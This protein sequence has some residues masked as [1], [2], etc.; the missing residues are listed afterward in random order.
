MSNSIT[1]YRKTLDNCIGMLCFQYR[2]YVRCADKDFSRSSKFTFETIIR[3]I[4]EF[5]AKSLQNEIN[6]HFYFN[7][8][9]IGTKSAFIQQRA[10]IKPHAFRQLFDMFLSSISMDKTFYGYRLVACDGTQINL[11]RNPKDLET[12]IISNPEGKSHNGMHM[13]ALFDLGKRVYIDYM[14]DS[15][16]H[17]HEL[18]NMISM[19]SKLPNPENTIMICDRGFGFYNSIAHL[20]ELGMRFLI[21]L[22]DIHSNGFIGKYGLP[23]TEFDM[24]IQKTLVCSNRKEYKDNPDYH[25]LQKFA[26]DYFDT[27]PEFPI[28]FRL[29]RFEIS[30][31]HFE[32]LATNL[33]RDTFPPSLLKE[34]Y[35]MR[36]GI[37]TYF[38]NLKYS[39]G[40]MYFHSLKHDSVIQ[41][42]HASMLML[43]FCSLVVSETPIAQK[44]DCKWEYHVNF[45][46][47]VAVCRVILRAKRFVPSEFYAVLFALNPCPTRPNR[48][49]K[50]NLHDTMPA[51]S[52]LY[53]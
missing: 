35:H 21:R 51:M 14:L 37:E 29:V 36:W 38:R 44:P 18:K 17:F 22:K 5:Q 27:A 41:E 4:L 26:F 3:I 16:C 11:P 45:A 53:R 40:M 46:A 13:T 34:L 25:I 23:D 19:A 12:T 39:L 1:G 2:S 31:G 28:A 8:K 30:P 33:P 6:D 49:F 24:D 52:F 9:K 47:A 32:V 48:H 42:I 15:A 10:K 43:N 7:P 50:R 20:N